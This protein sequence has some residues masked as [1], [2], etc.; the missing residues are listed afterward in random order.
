MNLVVTGSSFGIGHAL[1]ERLLAHGHT[2][3]GL[4]RSEQTGLRTRHPSTFFASRCDVS[5]WAEVSK[6]VAEITQR[7]PAID[8][9][10]TCAG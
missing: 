6:T 2:V 7:W 1:A 10:V 8:G 5:D 3:W 4:A 9:L